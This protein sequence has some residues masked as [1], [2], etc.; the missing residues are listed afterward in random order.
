MTE[1]KWEIEEVD[2]QHLGVGYF[3]RCNGCGASGGPKLWPN[4]DGSTRNS[5]NHRQ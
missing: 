2:G 3:Y 5:P 4:K 1:H